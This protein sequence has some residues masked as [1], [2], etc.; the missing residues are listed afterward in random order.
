M[1]AKGKSAAVAQMG[2]L[3][4]LAIVFSWLEGLVPAVFPIPGIKLGLSNVVTMYC[5]FLRG[6]RNAFLLAAL[7]AGFVLLTR[8]G[9]AALL[10]LSGGILSVAM[11]SVLLVLLGNKASYTTISVTGAIS[12]NI[13]QLLAAAYILRFGAVLWYYLPFLLL[14]GSIMGCLTAVLLR[15]L[16]PLLEKNHEI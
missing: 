8:G 7:K 15:A 1:Q 4:A 9:V 2:L 11:M 16:F 13:G 3:F 10:S 5:V 14:S 12:H 6:K